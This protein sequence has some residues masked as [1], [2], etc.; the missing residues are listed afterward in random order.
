M[1]LL[2]TLPR[3]SGMPLSATTYDYSKALAQFR[4]GKEWRVWHHYDTTRYIISDSSIMIKARGDNPGTSSP[5][6]FVGHDQNFEFCVKLCIDGDAEAGLLFYYDQHTFAG[7]GC[8]SEEKSFWKAGKRRRVGS[9]SF[10][11]TLWIKLVKR[12]NIIAAYMSGDGKKWS[13]QRIGIEVSA[14]QH[15]LL[16]GFLSLLPGIYCSGKGSV[17]VA[18]FK[19][20][21]I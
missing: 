2:L 6:L 3:G 10:G 4:L 13:Q 8:T 21:R 16:G 11:N 18:S 14:Y 12:D 7:F 20:K 1:D 17:L 19:Y 9:H 15:N 5:L